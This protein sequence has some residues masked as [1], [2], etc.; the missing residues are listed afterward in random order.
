VHKQ[1]AD[2]GRR[3]DPETEDVFPLFPVPERNKPHT[4]VRFVNDAG[5]YEPG[6]LA[7]LEKAK[8][9]PDAV[10]ITQQMLLWF[11]SDTRLYWL[12]GELYASENR[13]EEAQK[14]MDECVSEAR[15][16][17]NRKLLLTHRAAV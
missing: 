5:Q 3:P 2:A 13:L 11:P 1:Q 7:A 10:A 6:K 8:L 15:Q 16:Y 9:P 12:L 14:I 4:P 17:G